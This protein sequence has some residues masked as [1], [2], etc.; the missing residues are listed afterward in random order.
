MKLHHA[1]NFCCK[2]IASLFD[3]FALLK[4]DKAYSLDGTAKLLCYVCDVTCNVTV[5]E[6]CANK[7]LLEKANFLELLLHTSVNSAGEDLVGNDLVLA[8]HSELNECCNSLV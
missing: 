8:C 7:C 6:V 1:C 4:A 5:E 3:S 2:I